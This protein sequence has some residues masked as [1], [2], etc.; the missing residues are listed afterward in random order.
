MKK[1][2]LEKKL[3]LGDK[4]YLLN[5]D[6]FESEAAGSGSDAG[7]KKTAPYERFVG[8]RDHP[9]SINKED[10]SFAELVDSI[11][12]NGLIYPLLVR[13]TDGD[14]LEVVSGHRRLEACHDAGV[15]E[16]PYI[17]RDLDDFDATIMMVHS[18]FYRQNIRPSEKAR[19]YRMCM[20]AEKH[21]GVKGVDTAA[22]AGQDE[23]SKR[24]VYRY[25][26]VSYLS[27]YFLHLLDEGKLKF[28]AGVELAYLDESAQD[29]LKKF[30]EEYEIVPGINESSQLRKAYEE[31]VGLSYESIV[32][33]LSDAPKKKSGKNSVSIKKDEIEDYFG[34]DP[35]MEFVHDMIMRILEKYK[36]GALDKILGI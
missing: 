18:N 19:A 6:S 10:E 28:N 29:N 1:A 9:F 21:Q 24:Q 25:V 31:K 3:N 20:E 5:A 35:D 22:L 11:K 7:E 4:S 13:P 15:E 34:E 32:S 14:Q 23:D 27:D 36:E 8:F 33:L 30:I 26:R 16:I 17:L 2:D 12:R